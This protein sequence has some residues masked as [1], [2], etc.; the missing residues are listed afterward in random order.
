MKK[1]LD[2]LEA[3]VQWVALG[4]GVLWVLWMAW[5]YAI[6]KPVVA[7]IGNAELA[8]GSVDPYIVENAVNDLRGKMEG[9][10]SAGPIPSPKWAEAFRDGMAN[11]GQQIAE[12]PVPMAPI[13]VVEMRGFEGLTG[14]QRFADVPVEK[15]PTL[16]PAVMMESR[17]GM[18]NVAVPQQLAAAA[19]NGNAN[20]N[21]NGNGDADGGA[22]EAQPVALNGKD[23]TWIT[24]LYRIPMTDLARAFIDVKV[25]PDQYST[26]ILEVALQREE[27]LPDGSWSKLT[28]IKPLPTVQLRPL[29]PDGTRVKE[30]TDFLQWAN[31]HVADIVQPPFYQVLRGDAWAPP[32]QAPPPEVVAEAPKNEKPFDPKDWL[33]KTLEEKKAA[34]LTNDQIRAIAA[35]EQKMKDEERKNKS[36]GGGKSGG[37]GGGL[38]GMGGGGGLG[39]GGR[40]GGF[41]PNDGDRGGFQDPGAGD[42]ASGQRGQREDSPPPVPNDPGLGAPQDQPHQQPAA[43]PAAQYPLPNGEFDPSKSQGTDIIGWAHDDTCEAGKT[44]RYRVS[45]KLKSPLWNTTNMTKPQELA[46]TFALSSKESEWGQPVKVESL[47]HFWVVRPAFRGES[48]QVQVFR[49]SGGQ[50]RTKIFDVAPGDAVGAPDGDVDYGTGWTM[51]DMPTDARGERYVLLMDPHGRLQSRDFRADQADPKYK[52]MLQQANAAAAASGTGGDA[53]AGTR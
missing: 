32:G 9:T 52:E 31:T 39:G 45:Y 15:L 33:G 34:G 22:A 41:G 50:L 24:A 30:K 28:T 36:K 44:Y 40:G 38:G 13:Q 10:K 18:S 17:S 7:K 1:V 16:P 49:F 2:F 6:N 47:S 11:K 5:T 21:G 29:P 51:V 42:P 20:G 48:A 37:K 26:T 12:L 14:A 46:N 4:L 43:I 8:P 25:P 23:I 19:A 27:Q 3:N 35:L 53:V